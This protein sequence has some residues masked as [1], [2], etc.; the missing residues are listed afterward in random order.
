[1]LLME[2]ILNIRKL[3]SKGCS[4]STS[5]LILSNLETVKIISPK[6]HLTTSISLSKSHRSFLTLMSI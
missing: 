5:L 3:G 4:V 1:M 2:G 6:P